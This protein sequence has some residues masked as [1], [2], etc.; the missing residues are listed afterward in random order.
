MQL[1]GVF[2]AVRLEPDEP[3]S[4][5][6]STVLDGQCKQRNGWGLGSLQPEKPE[7][8]T[9]EYEECRSSSWGSADEFNIVFS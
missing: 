6:P 7:S 2:A 1:C 5:D 4:F 9:S 8:P 3:I